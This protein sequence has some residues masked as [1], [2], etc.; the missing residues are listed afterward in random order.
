[1]RLDSIRIEHF[2]YKSKIKFNLDG[3]SYE[4]PYSKM[5]HEK[6]SIAPAQKLLDYIDFLVEGK[7]ALQMKYG[8]LL[9]KYSDLIEQRA[10]EIEKKIAKESKE[11]KRKDEK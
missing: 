1:M 2:E 3:E 11:V 7:V 6:L 5:S 9:S 4:I 8:E 10:L